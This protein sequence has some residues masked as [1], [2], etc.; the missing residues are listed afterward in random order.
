MYG[1][2]VHAEG[3]SAFVLPLLGKFFVR[4][5]SDMAKVGKQVSSLWLR[6]DY[7]QEYWMNN[8]TKPIHSC[9]GFYSPDK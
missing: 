6:G 8:W 9:L 1:T 5:F 4:D 3:N 7:I 2:F